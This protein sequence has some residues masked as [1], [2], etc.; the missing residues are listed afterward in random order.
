MPTDLSQASEASKI[1]PPP[2]EHARRSRPKKRLEKMYP[3][4]NNPSLQYGKPMSRVA[5]SP[6][7]D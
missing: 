2:A 5:A 7:N 3:A 6:E 1:C 4:L